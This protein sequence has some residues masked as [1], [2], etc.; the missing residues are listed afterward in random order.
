M[1]EPARGRRRSELVEH[2][3]AASRATAPQPACHLADVLEVP[4]GIRFEMELGDNSQHALAQ[5]H[6]DQDT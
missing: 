4:Q 3:R 1:D 2:S 5:L 6:G